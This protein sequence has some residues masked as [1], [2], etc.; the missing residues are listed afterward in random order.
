MKLTYVTS[1]SAIIGDKLTHLEKLCQAKPDRLVFRAKELDEVSYEDFVCKLLPFATQ[2]GVELVLNHRIRLAKKYQL[3][4]Q[5]SVYELENDLSE[6]TF[7]VAVH[8]LEEAKLA[9][10]KGASWLVYGHLFPTASKIGAAPRSMAVLEEIIQ[11]EN[12]VVY[13]IGGINAKRLTTLPKG[14][15]G[16]CIMRDA[17]VSQDIRAF[18]NN[19]KM[20][21]KKTSLLD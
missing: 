20:Q 13:G 17:M 15:E 5:L 4:V 10:E 7:G 6:L 12:A 21:L 1:L 2:Y 19:L 18:T 9:L 8:S 16:V 14:L 11:L 3:K